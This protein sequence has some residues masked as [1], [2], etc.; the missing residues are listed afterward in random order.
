MTS[1]RINIIDKLSFYIYLLFL[2]FVAYIELIIF[3]VNCDK[4][5]IRRYRQTFLLN[6]NHFLTLVTI[7]KK[8]SR[9]HVLQ[10]N[11]IKI[12]RSVKDL[13]FLRRLIIERKPTKSNKHQIEHNKKHIESCINFIPPYHIIPFLSNTQIQPCNVSKYPS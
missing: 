5:G 10:V 1:I 9:I 13:K 4:I 6:I 12:H 7:L 3:K 11:H 8:R 2:Y